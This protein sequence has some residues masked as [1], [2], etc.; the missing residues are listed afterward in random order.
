MIVNNSLNEEYSSCSAILKYLEIF[1][2]QCQGCRTRNKWFLYR[3]S[4][5]LYRISIIRINDDSLTTLLVVANEN[6]TG[7]SVCLDPSK[8]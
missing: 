7:S 3:E 8:K 4:Y 1:S 5:I 6:L 2:P